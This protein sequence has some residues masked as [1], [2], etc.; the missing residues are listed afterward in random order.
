MA[1]LASHGGLRRTDFV[2]AQA[3]PN[4]KARAVILDMDT[5]GR[6]VY[7]RNLIVYRKRVTSPVFSRPCS[8]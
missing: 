5:L 3:D 8:L 1:S 7:T 6:Y 4:P 2:T